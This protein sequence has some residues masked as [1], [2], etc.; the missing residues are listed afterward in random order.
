ML[1]P[2][3]NLDDRSSQQFVD[4]AKRLIPH[5][6]PEWTDHNVSDPGVTLIELFA[7]MVEAMTYQLNRVPDKTYITL[8][9]LLGVTLC[10]QKPA[11][12]ELV[13]RLSAPVMHEPLTIPSGTTVANQVTSSEQE[14]SFQTDANLVLYPAQQ[15][16]C[17]ASPNGV[18]CSLVN[19]PYQGYQIFGEGV[20]RP[21]ACFYLIYDAS[22]N[23]DL[24]T[25]DLSN[26]VLTLSIT[27]KQAEGTG[28]DPYD[29][30]LTW[31]AYCKNKRWVQLHVERDL[32]L[33]LNKTGEVDLY[34]P[35]DL[36]KYAIKDEKGELHEG[37]CIRCGYNPS[38]RAGFPY[39]E[40]PLIQNIVSRTTG[41]LTR[42]SHAATVENE[43]LGYSNGQPGQSFF[44][45]RPPILPAE[46]SDD[47][48]VQV[49]E[50]PDGWKDWTIQSNFGASKHIDRHVVIDRN[51]G[52]VRFGPRIR[53]SDGTTLQHGMVP[54]RS[55]KIRLPRYR[56]GGGSIGNVGAGKLIVLKQ[57]VAYVDRVTNYKPA[58]GGLD[59]ETIEQAKLRALRRL[60]VHTR[61]VT[62]ADFEFLA[63]EAAPEQVARANCVCGDESDVLSTRPTINVYILPAVLYPDRRLDPQHDLRPDKDLL[64]K[65]QKYL[66]E[67]RVLTTY[68]LVLEPSFK[69][70]DVSATVELQPAANRATVRLDALERLNR[71][72]NPYIGGPQQN[73]WAFQRVPYQWEIEHILASVPGV[74][75]VRALVRTLDGKILDRLDSKDEDLS[76]GKGQLVVAGDFSNIEFVPSRNS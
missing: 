39:N 46:P 4:E 8:L 45:S 26:H 13:F 57:A 36:M 68:V 62:T 73:G 75:R 5:Y 20:P 60:Q 21:G 6:C 70:L 34:L 38:P 47:Q 32:T 72:L 15:R 35:P 9:E 3:P 37:Y 50:E 28:V 11:R 42:A 61:A 31:E 74:A 17:L 16:A 23:K 7:W 65:I 27:C 71:F 18:A 29:S 10:P 64:A 24:S 59:A 63:Q 67:R 56:T 19:L 54:P 52:E 69:L 14:I 76:L 44:V 25:K 51:S 43:I 40:S 58:E 33:A 49:Y 53:E 22:D 1:L 30:P 2:K 12:A 41:G 66:D 55:S 48:V